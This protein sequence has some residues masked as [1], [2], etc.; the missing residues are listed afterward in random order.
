MMNVYLAPPE[1]ADSA[2]EGLKSLADPRQQQFDTILA[3]HGLML[4]RIVASYEADLQLQQD[5][6]QEVSLAIWQALRKYR[7]DSELKTYVAKIAHNRCISHVAKA[8]RMPRTAAV[9]TEMVSPAST[10]EEATDSAHQQ[11]RLMRAV[12]SLP[13]IQREVVALALEGFTHVEVAKI[14]GIS[15][16][17]A[18]VR[19]ARAKQALSEAMQKRDAL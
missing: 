9:D 13:I 6:L 3:E 4:G 18:T 16:N 7:G 8:V 11:Q 1:A 12:R 14:L 10:P 2:L 5:L 19:F 17:N 15:A